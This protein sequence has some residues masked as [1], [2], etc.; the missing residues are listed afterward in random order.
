MEWRRKELKTK[1]K[2]ILKKYYWKM[3]LVSLIL[4]ILYGGS[5]GSAGSSASDSISTETESV[6]THEDYF[7]D[8]FTSD[9]YQDEYYDDIYE[10]TFEEDHE[11]SIAMIAG[12]IIGVLI[13][14]VI[15]LLLSF[16]LAAF[17]IN[18]LEVGIRRFFVKSYE[19]DVLIREIAHGFDHSYMN[20]VK[21]M[22]FR[23]LY[24]LLWTLLFIIP[25]IVKYYE[26]RMIPYIMG[27]NPDISKEEAFARSKEMMKGQKWKTFVLDMSFIG[28]NILSLFTLGILSV[29]YV[30]PYTN[31]TFAGLYRKLSNA[32]ARIYSENTTEFIVE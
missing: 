6:I 32:D 27:D 24:T 9:I 8:E 17:I 28:W 31:I 15:V 7:D 16:V 25:G 14:V 1:A 26:Y 20:V 29:F 2:E 30:A 5:G 21:T 12:I 18:P 4:T 22:F 23:D 19:G 10:D 3:V 13:V 11:T